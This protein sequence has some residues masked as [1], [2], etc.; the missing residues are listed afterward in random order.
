MV[1]YQDDLCAWLMQRINSFLFSG[2]RVQRRHRS[3]ASNAVESAV[4]FFTKSISLL[5]SNCCRQNE[6][7]IGT[8]SFG[9]Y[10]LSYFW[11]DSIA[12][13]G[14]LCTF[15]RSWSSI[16][17]LKISATSNRFKR[18]YTVCSFSSVFHLCLNN[19]N[20]T[21]QPR[22][23]WQSVVFQQL[24]FST[25]SLT[26]WQYFISV[27]FSVPWVPLQSRRCKQW[28]RKWFRSRKEAKSSYSLMWSII[29]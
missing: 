8:H 7:I 27:L 14:T 19:S 13:R 11:M 9:F 1:C 28:H 29:V 16:G 2:E 12:K 3:K 26:Q 18:Y 22:L 5:L 25:R 20:G 6:Y 24:A 17:T 4:I 23:L 10:S 21:I 15:I